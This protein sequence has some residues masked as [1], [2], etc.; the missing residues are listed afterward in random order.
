MSEEGATQTGDA[1]NGLS[2][3]DPSEHVLCYLTCPQD[4]AEA[5]VGA[6]MLTD[7]RARPLHFGYV[8]PI[9]PTAM[10]RLL[11]GPSLREHVLIDVIARK[12]LQAMPQVPEVVFVDAEELLNAR[13]LISSPMAFLASKDDSKGEHATLSSLVYRTQDNTDDRDRVGPIISVLESEIDLIEPF[14]RMLEALKEA[15]KTG[16]KY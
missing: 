3:T 2:G 1:D 11:Y 13:R 9:K 16:G 5:Y 8:S 4:A 12:L 15:T 6:L 7:G 14:T 10:Q